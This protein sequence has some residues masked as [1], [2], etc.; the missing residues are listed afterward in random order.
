MSKLNSIA[1]KNVPMAFNFG[2]AH[3]L[4]AVMLNNEPWFHGGDVCCCLNLHI[5][6]AGYPNVFNATRKLNNN[7]VTAHPIVSK[8]SDGVIWTRKQYFISESGLYKMIMRSDKPTAV[9]FQNW[10]TQEVLPSI[11]KTGG[12]DMPGSSDVGRLIDRVDKLADRLS[13]PRRPYL[14]SGHTR[15]ARLPEVKPEAKYGPLER[16]LGFSIGGTDKAD[17]QN[18]YSK[19]SICQ[20]SLQRIYIDVK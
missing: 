8:R 6:S 18:Q 17:R 13:G 14:G 5:N 9:P 1:E 2:D 7:E 19:A 15:L 12:Y 20:T 3:Q 10:V 11:R 16:F 4:R